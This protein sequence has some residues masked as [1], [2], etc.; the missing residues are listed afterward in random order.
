MT[1]RK[2]TK[3]EMR[4]YDLRHVE[5][6]IYRSAVGQFWVLTMAQTFLSWTLPEAR[7]DRAFATGT[8][9][10]QATALAAL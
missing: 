2:A 4:R 5:S 9:I 8:H 3:A 10:A 7:K 1:I 6:G